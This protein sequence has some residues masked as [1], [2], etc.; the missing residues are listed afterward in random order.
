MEKNPGVPEYA[1]IIDDT[2]LMA[3]A[4]D[5]LATILKSETQAVSVCGAEEGRSW[6]PTAMITMKTRR[7]Y[8][9]S[10]GIAR[11]DAYG[12]LYLRR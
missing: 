6:T 10:V 7:I 8:Y 12:E 2:A 9:E 3:S 5:G 1:K 11:V 4:K